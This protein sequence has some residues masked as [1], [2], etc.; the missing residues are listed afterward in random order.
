MTAEY[1]IET[2]YAVFNVFTCAPLPEKQMSPW[3][4]LDPISGPDPSMLA[5]LEAAKDTMGDWDG[6]YRQIAQDL[7][8]AS[9]DPPLADRDDPLLSSKQIVSSNSPGLRHQVDPRGGEKG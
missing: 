4:T 5:A 8:N 9:A 6:P 1:S 3:L 2:R 7:C